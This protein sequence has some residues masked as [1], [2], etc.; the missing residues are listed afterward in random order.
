MTYD[1]SQATTTAQRGTIVLWIIA[2]IISILPIRVNAIRSYRVL[3]GGLLIAVNE[4]TSQI[5]HAIVL[6]VPFVIVWV[7]T[8]TVKVTVKKQDIE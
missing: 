2:I 5:V 7:L 1:K 4:E 6:G 8:V 3:A